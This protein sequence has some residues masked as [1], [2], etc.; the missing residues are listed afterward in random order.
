MPSIPGPSAIPTGGSAARGPGAGQPSGFLWDAEAAFAARDAWR[1]LS[2]NA[3]SANPFYEPHALEA[4]L[5]NTPGLRA[6]MRFCGLKQQGQLVALWPFLLGDGRCGWWRGPACFTSPFI[7]ETL[8]LVSRDFAAE[9]DTGAWAVSLLRLAGSL[10]P[11]TPF[12]IGHCDCDSIVGAALLAGLERM[13]WPHRVFDL[14]ARPIAI[15]ADSYADFARAS[16]SDNRR[17]SLRRLRNRLSEAGEPGYETGMQPQA[18]S[19][20]AQEFLRL[21]AQGWK[22]RHGGAMA[23]SVA[24]RA[25][26]ERLFSP[27]A[28]AG[29]R[30]FDRLTVNGRTIALSLSLVRNGTVFLWK[31]AYDERFAKLGPGILLE[32]AIL[33]DMHESEGIVA[34]NSCALQK[35]ALDELFAQRHR[36]ADIVVAPP[37]S[38]PAS[39]MLSTE[40]IRRRARSTAVDLLRGLK[41]RL[42]GLD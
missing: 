35:T 18:C 33:R 5:G 8:P 2:R 14:V 26:C 7:T 10:A 19:D 15:R 6:R 22:G 30:R 13:R 42:K 3:L 29:T 17:R 28:P 23:A 21:E 9:D 39:A 12:V 24:T 20:A 37:G 31:S 4:M 38:G 16:H 27:D 41:T 1:D 25:M 11:A 32:D 40:A 36:I 34:L